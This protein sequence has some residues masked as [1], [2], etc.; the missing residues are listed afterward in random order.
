MQ[1]H[2]ALGWVSLLAI[3]LLWGTGCLAIKVC[4]DGGFGPFGLGATRLFSAAALIG[5]YGW[6]TRAQLVRSELPRILGAGALYWVVG[7]GL[8]VWGQQSVSSGG[9]ALILGLTPLVGALMSGPNLRTLAF[10]GLGLAGLGL[11]VDGPIQGEGVVAL[12]AASFV[13]AFASR[14]LGELQSDVGWVAGLQLGIGGAGQLVAMLVAREALPTPTP[15]AWLAWTWLVVGPAVVGMLAFVHAARTLP[16]TT[17][18]SHALVNP[19]VAL[20]LGWAVLSEPLGLPQ[21]AGLTLVLIGVGALLAQPNVP[22]RTRR[23]F[24]LLR[25]RRLRQLRRERQ[26]RQVALAARG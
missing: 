19:V 12:V 13:L 21:W 8:Q 18:L 6:W 1:N 17:V 3:Y 20:V 15:D 4:L 24:G 7:S 11:A 25:A 2:R 5:V 23:S 9:A 14:A 16:L 10:L 26:L 22:V